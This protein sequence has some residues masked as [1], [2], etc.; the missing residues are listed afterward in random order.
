[1]TLTAAGHNRRKPLLLIATY[2][3]MLPGVEHKK[4]WRVH[5]ASGGTHHVTITTKQTRVHEVYRKW[6]NVVD[7]HNQ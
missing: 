7:M 5:D 1:M 2:S 6:M 3:S 4:T